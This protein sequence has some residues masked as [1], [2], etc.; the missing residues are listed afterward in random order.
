MLLGWNGSCVELLGLLPGHTC[1]HCMFDFWSLSLYRHLCHTQAM[2][3]IGSLLGK[4]TLVVCLLTADLRHHCSSLVLI[5]VECDLVTGNVFNLHLGMASLAKYALFV[6][7]NVITTYSCLVCSH[8]R[9]VEM[10]NRHFVQAAEPSLRYCTR[11]YDAPLIKVAQ[12]LFGTSN[13][14]VGSADSCEHWW[15][16]QSLS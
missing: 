8:S 10:M 15:I 3:S 16:L 4:Q 14:L 2:S 13:K 11:W 1:L 6:Q 5:A 7:R 9:A 12:F